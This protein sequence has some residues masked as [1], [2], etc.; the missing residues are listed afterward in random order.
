M[1]IVDMSGNNGDN[2]SQD[3]NQSNIQTRQERHYMV[4]QQVYFSLLQQLIDQCSLVLGEFNEKIYEYLYYV[5]QVS[6]HIV[7]A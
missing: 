5:F 4:G 3:Q 2:H 7:S 1:D 6:W